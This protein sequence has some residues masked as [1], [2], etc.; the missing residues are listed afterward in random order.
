M[1]TNLESN[2]FKNA[3]LGKDINILHDIHLNKINIS[4]YQRTIQHLEKEIMHFLDQDIQIKAEGTS[5]NI[6]ETFKG[7]FLDQGFLDG[8]LLKDFSTL[9]KFFETTSKA[10]HFKVFISSIETDMC[11]RF[12]ADA[13]ELRLLCTYYGPATLW[14][15]EEAENRSAYYSGKENKQII[16]K[17]KLIQQAKTGDVLIL[18]GALYPNA[19]AII[20]RSPSIQKK[21]EK[22]L[23][24]RIDMNK[25]VKS[26]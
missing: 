9:L 12:H 4:I 7:Y 3:S 14:L 17:P 1:T 15:P 16:K 26:I 24:L 22:R 23:L 20:H 11:S 13:N 21:G 25:P 5:K 19:N 6:I 18:K 2:A 8:Y 10:T